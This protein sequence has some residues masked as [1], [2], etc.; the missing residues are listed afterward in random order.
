MNCITAFDVWL[1]MT[2]VGLLCRQFPVK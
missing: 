2:A 1:I